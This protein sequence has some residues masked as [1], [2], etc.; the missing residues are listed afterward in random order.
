MPRRHHVE[1]EPLGAPSKRDW[2][3]FK[4]TS[5]LSKQS[6]CWEGARYFE[7][8]PEREGKLATTH[9][10]CLWKSSTVGKTC[11]PR[12]SPGS[13]C[14]RQEGLSCMLRCCETARASFRQ[15]REGPVAPGSLGGFSSQP[16]PT[17]QPAP[18]APRPTVIPT[19]PHNLG[20]GLFSSW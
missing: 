20:C 2:P 8:R 10:A 7:D 17:V 1:W 6:L 14:L 13:I 5:A 12:A 15:E 11:S 16:F 19:A 18:S 9:P 4:V 3:Y